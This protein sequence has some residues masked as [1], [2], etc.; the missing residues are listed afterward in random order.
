MKIPIVNIDIDDDN[1]KFI[2]MILMISSV[3]YL[4][5][6]VDANERNIQHILYLTQHGGMVRSK[7]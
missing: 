2:Y 7:S 4:I 6:Q 5:S 3:V 1:L